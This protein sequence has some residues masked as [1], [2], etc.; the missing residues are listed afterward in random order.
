MDNKSMNA[1]MT[2]EN[3]LLK[4]LF[5]RWRS[6]GDRN[7]RESQDCMNGILTEVVENA[8]FLSVVD[9]SSDRGMEFSGDGTAV[10][11]EDTEMSFK[12]LSD[13][14]GNTYF[15]AFTDWENSLWSTRISCLRCRFNRLRRLTTP[16]Y[17]PFSSRIGK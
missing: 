17:L 8:Q 13:D 14:N 7:S 6:I 10:L 16:Q 12:T 9:I 15:P 11:Q 1:A 5:S 4:E 3:P 2:V